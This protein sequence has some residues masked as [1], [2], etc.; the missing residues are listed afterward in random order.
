MLWIIHLFTYCVCAQ[1]H[2]L[3]FCIYFLFFSFFLTLEGVFSHWGLLPSRVFIK[4]NLGS[5]IQTPRDYCQGKTTLLYQSNTADLFVC[6]WW[7]FLSDF[8]QKS[9]MENKHSWSAFTTTQ[10][11]SRTQETNTGR[12]IKCKT[13]HWQWWLYFLLLQIK[14]T[15]LRQLKIYFRVLWDQTCVF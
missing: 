6:C 3:P 1:N 7:N 9:K 4:R 13:S 10:L 14:Q 2:C 8:G 11:H 15:F 5:S 12:E